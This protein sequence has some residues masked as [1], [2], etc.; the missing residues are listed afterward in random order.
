[1]KSGKLLRFHPTAFL[2]VFNLFSSFY[3]LGLYSS[4]QAM[5]GDL[6]PS[7]GSGGKITTS[8]GSSDDVGNA[9]A[10]QTDGKIVAA[11]YTTISGSA[12]FAVARY[13]PDGTLDAG[14]GSGGQVT[15]DFGNGNDIA[16]AVVI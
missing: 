16:R 2:L 9:V 8:F 11:G 6:D 15:T 1:M 13:N 7:F 4:A 14:F 5:P 3:F 12:A 10:I